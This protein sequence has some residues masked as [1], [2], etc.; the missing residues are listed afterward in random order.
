MA[1]HE[2]SRNPLGH[3]REDRRAHRDIRHKMAVHDVHVQPFS[4]SLD[5]AL[6]FCSELAKVGGKDGW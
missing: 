3:T 2:D 5:H 6:A 1:I 4:A